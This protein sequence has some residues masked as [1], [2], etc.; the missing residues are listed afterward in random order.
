MYIEENG[1]VRTAPIG[2][3]SAERAVYTEVAKADKK[4]T[5]ILV[6][7]SGKTEAAEPLYADFGFANAK[8]AAKHLSLGDLLC[9]VPQP[10]ALGKTQLC[11]PALGNKLCAAALAGLAAKT[12]AVAALETSAHAEP[13]RPHSEFSRTLPCVWK[14]MR[15]PRLACAYPTAFRSATT[16]Q[17]GK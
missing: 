14:P 9:F 6:P 1:L 16:S 17:C 7:E 12:E 8:E 5:G 10:V 4:Y 3:T 13:L 11:A 15:E 2:K